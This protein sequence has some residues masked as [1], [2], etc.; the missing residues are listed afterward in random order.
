MK[1]LT[2]EINNIL[3]GYYEYD[4]DDSEGTIYIYDLDHRNQVLEE[5]IVQDL[6]EALHFALKYSPRIK[7]SSRYESTVMIQEKSYPKLSFKD[8]LKY[9]LGDMFESFLRFLFP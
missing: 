3:V 9:L 2:I 6:P 4:F 1:T 8:H 5:K 7:S